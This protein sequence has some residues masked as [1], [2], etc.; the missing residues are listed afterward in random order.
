MHTHQTKKG[1][2]CFPAVWWP[3]KVSSVEG[4]AM[5]EREK[6]YPLMRTEDGRILRIN[7]N[8]LIKIETKKELKN[9]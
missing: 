9:D 3:V 2:L 8:N 6:N 5:I 4:R 1:V 7:K